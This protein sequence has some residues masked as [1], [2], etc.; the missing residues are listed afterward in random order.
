VVGVEVAALQ[1]RRRRPYMLTA[2]ATATSGSLS[3]S[4]TLTLT[5]EQGRWQCSRQVRKQASQARS[6]GREES[7][8][9][10]P[11]AKLRPHWINI[12]ILHTGGILAR[13]DYTA[14]YRYS[15]FLW[16]FGFLWL[17]LTRTKRMPADRQVK[18]QLDAAG[19]TQFLE[20]PEEVVLDGICSLKGRRVWNLARQ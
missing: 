18:Q 4:T 17:Y 7:C 19:H 13:P 12:F 11:P 10:R 9:G 1:L 3:H 15:G 16:C 5:V 2:T 6:K 14:L 8:G 20:C